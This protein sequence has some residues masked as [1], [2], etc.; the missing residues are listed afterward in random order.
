LDDNEHPEQTVKV[1][2]RFYVYPIDKSG[3][4]RKWRYARQSVDEIQNLLRAKKTKGG[5]DIEL[6]KNFGLYKTVWADPRYD[7][8]GYGTQIVKSLVPGC[9]F[10]FPK[11]LWNVYDC[12]YAAVADDKEAIVLDFF[13]GSGTTA[14]ALLELNKEDGGKRKFIIC[15]QMHYVETITR[16]RV[17]Q[18]I[19]NNGAGSFVYCELMQANQTF[20]DLIQDAKSNKALQTIWN[21]MQEKAFLSYRADS[22]AIDTTSADFMALSLD[23]QKRFLIEVLDKNMLYVPLSEIDDK[24]YEISVEDKKLNRQFFSQK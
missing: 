12:L 9:K 7:A 3:V 11:S 17:H 6:G 14:H 20:V 24:T 8:N 5:Y 18:V 13:C 22:K 2:K 15:E 4:E 19:K 23:D 21:E 16:E 10:D 1:G